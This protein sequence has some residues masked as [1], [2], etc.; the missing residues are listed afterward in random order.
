MQ[1]LMAREA[2]EKE[3]RVMREAAEMAQRQLPLDG[4]SA[5]AELV[6]DPTPN[7]TVRVG[8]PALNPMGPPQPHPAPYG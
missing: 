6:I 8:T 2:A 5:D 1:E 4:K 7:E 3:E